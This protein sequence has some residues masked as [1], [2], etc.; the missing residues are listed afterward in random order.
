MIKKFEIKELEILKYFLGIEVSYSRHGIFI[1]QQK[2]VTNLLKEIGKLGCKPTTTPLEPNQKL[3]EAK[4]E[5]VV[6]KEMY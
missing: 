5:P 3:G 1:S 4:E 6:D 2:Y